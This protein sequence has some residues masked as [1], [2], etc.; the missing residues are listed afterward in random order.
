[1]PELIILPY[2]ERWPDEFLNLA[3]PVRRALG[4]KALRIDHIGSTAIPGLAAKDVIDIQVTVEDLDEAVPV[5]VSLGYELLPIR[6]DHLPPGAKGQPGEWDKRLFRQPPELRRANLHVRRAGSANQRY[7]LLFRDYLR[8]HPPAAAAYGLIK[9]ALVR[10]HP[11][12]WDAYYEV[13]DPVCDLIWIA[14]EEWANTCGWEPG[15]SDY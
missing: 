7:A 12:D 2:N 9:R 14:A 6:R 5:L 4:A 13:K 10:L 3:G 15:P 8:A 1:M 11:S